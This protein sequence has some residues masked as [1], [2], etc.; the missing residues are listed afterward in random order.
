MLGHGTRPTASVSFRI[1]VSGGLDLRTVYVHSRRAARE[2]TRWSVFVGPD[3]EDFR[4]PPSRQAQR[5]EVSRAAT[6]LFGVQI[7]IS[8]ETSRWG[9]P[10]SL[11]GRAN[12][13]K[14]S[15]IASRVQYVQAFSLINQCLHPGVSA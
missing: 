1:L 9:R 15:Y 11:V 10:D 4:R 14:T 13:H 7:R 12:L 3:G 2:V 6:E 8:H 5:D